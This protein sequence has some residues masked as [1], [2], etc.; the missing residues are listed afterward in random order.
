VR[1]QLGRADDV[2]AVI[3]S[4]VRVGRDFAGVIGADELADR[5]A[6]WEEFAPAHLR[7]LSPRQGVL[8]ATLGR[9]R[10]GQ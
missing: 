1:V 8:H 4:A 9:F 5:T 7:A 3:R 10:R 2:A 6:R